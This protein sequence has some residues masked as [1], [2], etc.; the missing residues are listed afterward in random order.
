MANE[1]KHLLSGYAAESLTDEERRDLAL[2]A[3]DD[4]EVFD[5][6]VVPGVSIQRD[7]TKLIGIQIN[8][9][10]GTAINI[11]DTTVVLLATPIVIFCALTSRCTSG[12]QTAYHCEN[13]LNDITGS[14]SA[15]I[16]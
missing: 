10:I 14:I 11:T 3:L 7:T 1:A 9:P 5:Q 4:Q 13:W 12:A 15:N 6:L 16:V 8:K 2:A